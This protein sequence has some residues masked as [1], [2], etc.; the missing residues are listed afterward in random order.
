MAPERHV[1]PH[2]LRADGDGT[3]EDPGRVAGSGLDHVFAR[4]RLI[5]FVVFVLP[6]VDDHGL[7]MLR[8]GNVAGTYLHG[9]LESAA[10]VSEV[11]GREIPAAA[12]KQRNYDLLAEWFDRHQRGFAEMYL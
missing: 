11:L 7:L 10:V 8:I 1:R 2:Q 4:D 5:K 9:A 12:P 3:D 6:G